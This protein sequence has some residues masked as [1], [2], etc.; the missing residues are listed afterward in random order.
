MLL[1]FSRFDNGNPLN[2]LFRVCLN[3][4]CACAIRVLYAL[5]LYAYA[6]TP[7]IYFINQGNHGV[8]LDTQ[9]HTQKP[10]HASSHVISYMWIFSNC[11]WNNEIIRGTHG[12][13]KYYLHWRVDCNGCRV[14]HIKLGPCFLNG[15]AL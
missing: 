8:F 4:V 6:N 11:D 5:Y 3:F 10:I 15:F 1:F 14:V 2:K 9:R 12:I 13:M 7:T